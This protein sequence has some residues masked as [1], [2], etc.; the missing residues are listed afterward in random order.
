M[1]RA[2][3]RKTLL[4]FFRADPVS[5]PVVRQGFAETELP[6]LNNAIEQYVQDHFAKVE[7][8]GATGAGMSGMNTT[9][10][11]VVAPQGRLSGLFGGYQQGAVQ[12]RT[13]AVDVDATQRCVERGIFLVQEGEHRIAIYLHIDP[14]FHKGGINIEVM[15]ANPDIASR[16]LAEIQSRSIKNSVYRGK[17]LSLQCGESGCSV[18]FHQF[19]PLSR[20]QIVL[21]EATMRLLERNTVGFFQNA[22]ALR[23]SGR[24]VRRGLLLHGKPGTGKTHVAK[25]LGQ[26]LPN[27]TVI[28]MSGEELGL[29]KQGCQMGRM[30]APAL[31]VLEDVDLIASQRDESRHPMYQITLHQLLNEMD[32]VDSGAEIIFLLTT[33]RPE[34]IEEAIIMRPGR[35]DQAIEFALPDAECRERLLKLYCH[36][37]I[38]RLEEKEKVVQRTEGASPAFIKELVRKASLIAAEQRMEEGG[39]LVVTDAHFAEALEEMVFGGGEW[40]RNLLGFSKTD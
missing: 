7:I 4:R 40:T 28:V 1:P 12:Y 20:E 33:N 19:P 39:I 8:I 31:I 10:A 29:L 15:C 27:V 32:G 22:E 35:I 11:D 24:S 2:D 34:A 9:F 36:G 25:W 38:L 18:H 21:P 6:N 13:V 30:L 5:L 14:W 17:I 23:K 3:L 37:L 26:S 16:V